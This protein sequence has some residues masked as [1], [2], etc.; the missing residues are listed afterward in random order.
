MILDSKKSYYAMIPADV[1][2]DENLIPGAKLLYGE[3][4]ALCNEKGYCWATDEYFAKLYGTSK[5][6][7]Q[8]WLKSLSDAGYITL[9]FVRNN[10][11]KQSVV[12]LIKIGLIF[13][14][15][16][17]FSCHTMTKMS[18]IIIQ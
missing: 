16:E 4:T 2:Y 6:A 7:I 12:R 8:R 14:N 1:R 5:R 13:S 15:R 18:R 3:I 11:E 17:E 9:E 10:D